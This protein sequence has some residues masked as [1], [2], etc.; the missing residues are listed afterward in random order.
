MKAVLNGIWTVLIA[1]LLS[2]CCAAAGDHGVTAH[3][4][5]EQVRP[6]EVFELRVEMKR[7][8]YG[9]FALTVPPHGSLHRVA[10]ESEPVKLEDGFYRQRESWMLQ[11]DRSGEI[12]VEGV[13]VVMKTGSGE[14]PVVLPPLRM[15]VLPWRRVDTSTEPVGFPEPA[16]DLEAERNA[17]WWLVPLVVCV[18]LCGWWLRRPPGGVTS[19]DSGA[20]ASLEEALDDLEGGVLC[21]V[22]LERLVIERGSEWSPVLREAAEEAVYAAR[23][24]AG[25][26]AALLRREVGA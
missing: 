1:M 23:G 14:V 10:V 9:R 6:G 2:V 17:W 11:A 20:E 7:A 19:G 15:E 3:F 12:V 26:L 16:A 5:P 21:S 25:E 24:D 18:G 22:A 8:D 13:A 4:V